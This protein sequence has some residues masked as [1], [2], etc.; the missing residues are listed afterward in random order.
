MH[1]THISHKVHKC[2]QCSA[3]SASHLRTKRTHFPKGSV[4]SVRNVRRR[5]TI[6][7]TH[8]LEAFAGREACPLGL[9]LIAGLERPQ[10]GAGFDA[11]AGQLQ[12]VD[13]NAV[14]FVQ[15]AGEADVAD[16]LP[17]VHWCD[18]R[19]GGFEA[20]MVARDLDHVVEVFCL[21]DA[22]YLLPFGVKTGSTSRGL[23]GD[24]RSRVP[25]R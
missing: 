21:P 2:V 15:P 7:G 6:R 12:A 17:V 18:G 9:A 22:D 19:Q 20:G 1:K 16:G 10:R 14:E 25:S 8:A 3:S 24:K 11:P 23:P 4:R 5:Y 13:G